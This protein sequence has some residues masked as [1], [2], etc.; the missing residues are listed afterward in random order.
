MNINANSTARNLNVPLWLAII[1][2]LVLGAV[3]LYSVANSPQRKVATDAETRIAKHGQEIVNA[4]FPA[5]LGAAP[6]R[7][8]ILNGVERRDDGYQ[9]LTTL[10]YTNILLDDNHLVIELNYDATGSYLGAK[11]RHCN[12]RWAEPETLIDLASR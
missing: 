7:G 9:V 2:G 11:I 4:A 1:A 8:V 3:W 5:R 12:D 6:Y 10:F